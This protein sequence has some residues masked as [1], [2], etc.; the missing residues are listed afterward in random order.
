MA[1]QI[2]SDFIIHPFR[3]F[4]KSFLAEFEGVL[5][6]GVNELKGQLE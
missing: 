2:L 3:L 4:L 6:D 5:N 1:R